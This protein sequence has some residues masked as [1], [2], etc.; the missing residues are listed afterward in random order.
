MANDHDIGEVINGYWNV[1]HRADRIINTGGE[2][3]IPELV[4]E[5]ILE[6]PEISDCKVFGME[7]EKW[8]YKLVAQITPA[9]IEISSLISFLRSKLRP[10][11]IPKEF[12][13]V[14]EIQN[15]FKDWKKPELNSGNDF[16]G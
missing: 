5:K 12:I 8:G 10:Y 9:S 11:E 15:G 14:N 6:F 3:V 13:R 16:I 4:E 1:L 7:D 2:K